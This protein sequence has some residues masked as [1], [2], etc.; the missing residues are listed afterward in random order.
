[1]F[2]YLSKKTFKYIIPIPLAN[3]FI[4]H[5]I[6]IFLNFLSVAG[7][8]IVSLMV[9]LS[10][11]IGGL[12]V[13]ILITISI[14]AIKNTIANSIIKPYNS[15]P[16]CVNVSSTIPIIKL[17]A[18]TIVFLYIFFVAANLVLSSFSNKDILQLT[19]VIYPIS[20]V[21]AYIE[22]NIKKNIVRTF[23]SLDI[24]GIT[25]KHIDDILYIE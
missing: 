25:A 2:K 17:N 1:M 4:P 6:R 10:S 9:I 15:Y 3:L 12:Y 19:K 22:A 21:I 11:F 23:I 18:K 16:F 8:F 5:V 20:P 24:N 14:N 13:L 7:I